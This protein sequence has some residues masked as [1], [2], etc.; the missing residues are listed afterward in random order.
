M[1]IHPDRPPSN[2]PPSYEDINLPI[3][4]DI[5]LPI[6][7]PPSNSPPSY[8]DA[9]RDLKLPPGT[10]N[11]SSQAIRETGQRH[12]DTVSF[13]PMPT[14]PLLRA[15]R[16]MPE[17]EQGLL[18]ESAS[19][20]IRSSKSASPQASGRLEEQVNSM[21]YYFQDQNKLGDSLLMAPWGTYGLT[22][23]DS[24]E[25]TYKLLVQTQRGI[26]E[27]TIELDE[28]TQKL[29]FRG[30]ETTFLTWGSAV[31][32]GLGGAEAGSPPI[33]MYDFD[34]DKAANFLKH[35][36]GKPGDWLLRPSSQQGYLA[37]T[38]CGIN[39]QGQKGCGNSLVRADGD[40]NCFI[41]TKRGEYR[42]NSIEDAAKESLSE[43]GL[44]GS[45]RDVKR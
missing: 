6:N 23:D 28:N 10:P 45:E 18:N 7:P 25:N 36:V 39:S 4:E 35:E 24:Q 11:T 17:P 31:R 43:W 40:N 5:N 26:H 34:R 22:K 38:V 41:V 3:N 20:S 32:E 30:A 16:R 33:M 37:L 8:E 15:F 19:T 2:P 13:T 29:Q 44:R 27:S 1:S 42:V 9:V 21:P 12:S 14:D